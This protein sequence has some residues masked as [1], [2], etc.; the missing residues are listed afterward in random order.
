MLTVVHTVTIVLSTML[1]IVGVHFDCIS[2]FRNILV[3][4][5]CHVLL[6]WRQIHLIMIA[7]YDAQITCTNME[8]SKQVNRLEHVIKIY[9]REKEI[10]T[11][12]LSASINLEWNKRFCAIPTFIAHKLY[13]R[14][15][16]QVDMRSSLVW[17]VSSI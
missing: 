10:E 8:Q 12:V 2:Y 4:L 16:V 17:H 9:E 3:T 15:S 5:I 6:T 1:N 13:R 14:W 7:Y 11:E